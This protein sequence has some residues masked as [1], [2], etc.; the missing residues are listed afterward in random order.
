MDI[1]KLITEHSEKLLLGIVVI[2]II[3]LVIIIPNRILPLPD[4]DVIAV[5]KKLQVTDNLLKG[6]PLPKFPELNQLAKIKEKWGKLTLSAELNNWTM[7]CPTT[8]IIEFNEPPKPEPKEIRPPIL[9][10]ITVNPD[11]PNK[12]LITWG[13]DTA[14]Y[15]S[16]TATLS[17][18][19]IYRRSKE[20]KEIRLLIELKASEIAY[21]D[22]QDIQPETE[23]QY[24]I[25]SFTNEKADEMK[26][27]K[28]ESSPVNSQVIL[29]PEIVRLDALEVNQADNFVYQWVYIKIDKYMEGKW[30]SILDFFKKGER[31][32]KDKFI[33]NYEI[34]DIKEEEQKKSIDPSDPKR[35]VLLK[36]YKITLR[37][38][39]SGKEKIIETKPVLK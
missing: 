4:S 21:T 11:Q 23:Y 35:V 30:K 19:R 17:G 31:V 27:N 26:E 7:Y 14:I 9:K 10:G 1:K 29:T 36:T 33:T 39:K 32:G 16:P 22:E 5:N 25:T 13:K 12:V 24:S 8:Y 6:N 2:A 20:D 3:L 34:K 37:H 15:S 28:T 18:Y 38:I